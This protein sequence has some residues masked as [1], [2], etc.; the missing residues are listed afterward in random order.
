MS[1]L[2]MSLKRDIDAYFSGCLTLT[3]D[4]YKKNN[5]K[6]EGIYIVD[7]LYDYPQKCILWKT[8]KL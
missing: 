8:I 6:R 4:R 2:L 3:L 5:I 7:P 1:L